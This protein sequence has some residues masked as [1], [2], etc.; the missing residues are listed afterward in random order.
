MTGI[1]IR[2]ENRDTDQHTG[3]I[4]RDDGGIVKNTKNCQQHRELGGS[5]D[6]CFPGAFRGGCGHLDF[7]LLASRIVKEEL[8]VV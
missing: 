8:S 6:R 7:A 5:K 2:I 4:A 3:R 1:L